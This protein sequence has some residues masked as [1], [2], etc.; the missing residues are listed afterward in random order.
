MSAP[1]PVLQLDN[2]M[3]I[4]TVG[5]PISRAFRTNDC[6]KMENNVIG[7]NS[8]ELQF[9]RTNPKNRQKR[10]RPEDG[11]PILMEII[12]LVGKLKSQIHNYC[13]S[14]CINLQTQTEKDRFGSPRPNGRKRHLLLGKC[15]SA[16]LLF[17][18]L[19][20]HTQIPDFCGVRLNKDK[21][22]PERMNAI[23]Y[24]AGTVMNK[25]KQSKQRS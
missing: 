14:S 16:S 15:F 25:I 9:V 7:F 8:K 21:E 5:C 23:L 24:D 12:G 4:A 1:S 18:P 6:D 2:E 19:N 22:K 3:I 10:E 20:S 17:I 11:N 13:V